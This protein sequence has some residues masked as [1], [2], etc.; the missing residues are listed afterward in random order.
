MWDD[1]GGPEVQPA[2]LKLT[3][4]TFGGNTGAQTVSTIIR[5][6][7]K[8]SQTPTVMSGSKPMNHAS[9]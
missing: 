6:W 2:G 3:A 4:L 1:E 9:V 8:P 7:S 5:F